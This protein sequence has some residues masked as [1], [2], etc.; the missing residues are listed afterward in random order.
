MCVTGSQ[1]P[2]KEWI[3]IED[4]PKEKE[5]LEVIYVN[6]GIAN[7]FDNHIELN[8][9]L[10]L[11]QYKE[12]HDYA[13]NHEKQHT[14]KKATLWDMYHD[15]FGDRPMIVN[16]QYWNLIL[17]YPETR[18]QLSPFYPAH[19]KVYTDINLLALYIIII[20][21]SIVMFKVVF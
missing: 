18:V 5:E 6:H 9:L 2:S 12:L 16:R 21:F 14:S 8:R 7:R 19:G 15:F 13:L 17:N 11:P 1:R 20:A 4:V 3:N 10:L